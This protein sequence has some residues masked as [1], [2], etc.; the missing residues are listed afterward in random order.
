[1]FINNGLFNC[2]A[3][4]KAVIEAHPTMLDGHF[5]IDR[6]GIVRWMNIEAP[7]DL[8]E[9]GEQPNLEDIVAAARAMAA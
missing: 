5:M 4:E 7:N 9:F 8:S 2:Y 6:D 3:D 1:M